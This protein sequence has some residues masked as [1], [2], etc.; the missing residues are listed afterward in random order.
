VAAFAGLEDGLGDVDAQEVVLAG[1]KRP[2]S[3]VNTANARS[4]GASTTIRWRT[5]VC[6]AVL[7]NPPCVG[8][9]QRSCRPPG[10]WTRTGR[11]RPQG[12]EAVGVDAVD[13][14]V[15]RALADHEPASLRT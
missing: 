13:A 14:A 15:A 2:K 9:R 4:I 7:M 8:V 5:D 6:S 3:S 10:C 12:A 1:L 11:D